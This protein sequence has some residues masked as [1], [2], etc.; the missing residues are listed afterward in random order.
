M[1]PVYVSVCQTHSLTINQLYIGGIAGAFGVPSLWRSGV[2]QI[3]I[4]DS[5]QVVDLT[6]TGNLFVL[7]TTVLESFVHFF[8]CVCSHLSIRTA[9]SLVVDDKAG[10]Y[11]GTPGQNQVQLYAIDSQNIGT[12][13]N[14]NILGQ[15]LAFLYPTE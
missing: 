3:T 15:F 14:F 6:L 1:C 8:S 7:G 11:F 2:N 4:Y 13:Q 5:F 9:D 10:I 12:N